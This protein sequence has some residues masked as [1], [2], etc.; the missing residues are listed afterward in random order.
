M[1]RVIKLSNDYS[2][3]ASEANYKKIHGNRIRSMSARGR[4]AKVSGHSNLKT[5]SPK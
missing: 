5:L 2:S 1:K 4:V 3:I